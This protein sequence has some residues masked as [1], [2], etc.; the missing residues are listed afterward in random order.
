MNAHNKKLSL[1]TVSYNKKMITVSNP[2]ANPRG[3]TAQE[4]QATSGKR[5]E[6]TRRG[7]VADTT[8]EEGGTVICC[9]MVIKWLFYH[10]GIR[11]H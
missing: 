11:M 3:G 5:R 8:I 10:Y 7:E 4:V 2:A 9:I 6:G 1:V